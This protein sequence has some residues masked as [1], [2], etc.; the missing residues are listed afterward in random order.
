MNEI[1]PQPT[2]IV[3]A[4][5]LTRPG[6]SMAATM[7]TCVA[8]EMVAKSY[9]FMMISMIEPTPPGTEDFIGAGNGELIPTGGLGAACRN[10]AGKRHDHSTFGPYRIGRALRGEIRQFAAKAIIGTGVQQIEQEAVGQVSTFWLMRTNND[11]SRAR[12][13]HRSESKMKFTFK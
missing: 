8:R 6:V 12:T 3:P 11:R 13:R 7:A 2:A 4:E 5:I 10:S 1:L 9:P